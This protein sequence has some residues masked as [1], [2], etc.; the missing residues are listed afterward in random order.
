[1]KETILMTMPVV[2]T[3]CEADPERQ[4]QMYQILERSEILRNACAQ[5]ALNTGFCTKTIEFS[6]IDY[7]DLLR[8]DDMI[9]CINPLFPGDSFT[10]A[11]LR[12]MLG[13]RCPALR[14]EEI[15]RI[16]CL[17]PYGYPCR[18]WFIDVEAQSMLVELTCKAKHSSSFYELKL[19]GKHGLSFPIEI[20][21]QLYADM[22]DRDNH[23][24]ECP[25]YCVTEHE[26]GCPVGQLLDGPG[27]LE[28][29]ELQEAEQEC[30]CGAEDCDCSPAVL[31]QACR[32][33]QHRE[34][35]VLVRPWLETLLTDGQEES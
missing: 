5:L 20:S 7:W 6:R 21:F 25:R 32:T 24:D 34:E 35:L 29:S 17:L 33:L 15:Q 1:M 13:G 18:E 12:A 26:D 16:C 31:K 27:D 3:V 22:D 4:H 9:K 11:G 19:R 30:F 8:V 14:A 28:L 23:E 2:I 10:M